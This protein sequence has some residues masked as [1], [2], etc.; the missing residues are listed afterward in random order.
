[1]SVFYKNWFTHNIIPLDDLLNEHRNVYKFHEFKAKY[2]FD[3]PFTV[4]YGLIDAIPNAWK[5]KI[6]RQNQSGKVNQNDNTTLNTSSIYSSIL[7]S[8]F[9]LPTS[10]NRI[11]YHGFT[12]NNVHKVYQ[13][14]FTITKK[15]T[16]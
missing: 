6:K 7:E 12:E 4:F 11:L 3:V 9:V 15:L 13:L 2:N 14:P 5:D 8:S 1:M 16:S 10:Q